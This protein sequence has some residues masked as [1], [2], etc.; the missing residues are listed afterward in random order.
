MSLGQDR[1][2]PAAAVP[3]NRVETNEIQGDVPLVRRQTMSPD[4]SVVSE[5][6]AGVVEGSSGGGSVGEAVPDESL[7]TTAPEMPQLACDFAPWVGVKLGPDILKAVKD[8]GRP[9]RVLS[10][11]SAMTMDF[12]PSRINFDVD[13]GGIITRVWCG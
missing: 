11:D 9:Y 13:Q 12:S 2:L 7:E 5:A 10:P 4:V 1:P 3:Q 6:V 8:S